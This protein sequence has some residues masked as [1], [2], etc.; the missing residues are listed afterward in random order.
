MLTDGL[1]QPPHKEEKLQE[2]FTAGMMTDDN[3]SHRNF[4]LNM[5]RFHLCNTYCNYTV[6]ILNIQ[7]SYFYHYSGTVLNPYIFILFKIKFV[8]V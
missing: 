6:M 4:V 1:A 5:H 2:W 3:L 8:T 7:S